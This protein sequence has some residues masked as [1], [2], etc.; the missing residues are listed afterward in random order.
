MLNDILPFNHIAARNNYFKIIDHFADGK[1]PRNHDDTG[2]LFRSGDTTR[3]VI[4]PCASIVRNENPLSRIAREL[5]VVGAA[6][7]VLP[8]M[9]P[10][11]LSKEGWRRQLARR[12]TGLTDC[13]VI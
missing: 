1:L 4:G 7:R 6:L 12:V 10:L 5:S 11:R 13:S 3:C 8:F 9:S 2:N